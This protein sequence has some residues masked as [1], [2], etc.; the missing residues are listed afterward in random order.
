M[1]SHAGWREGGEVSVWAEG[2]LWGRA[3]AVALRMDGQDRCERAHRSVYRRAHVRVF[4][5]AAGLFSRL[6]I[7]PH[8]D[9]LVHVIPRSYRPHTVV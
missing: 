7:I 4:V 9:G 8:P 5:R 1:S 6:G 3:S 2:Q